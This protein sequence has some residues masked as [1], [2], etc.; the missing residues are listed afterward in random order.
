[1]I[2]TATRCQEFIPGIRQRKEMCSGKTE[3]QTSFSFGFDGGEGEGVG[4]A[5]M[6]KGEEEGAHLMEGGEEMR[7]LPLWWWREGERRYI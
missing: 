6:G 2:L 7:V 4:T 1:M 5:A 3:L